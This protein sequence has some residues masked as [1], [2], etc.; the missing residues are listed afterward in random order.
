MFSSTYLRWGGKLCVQLEF[1]MDCAKNYEYRLQF[2]QVIDQS[3][4]LVNVVMISYTVSE[5]NG[6]IGHKI[7]TWFRGGGAF[8]HPEHPLN[9]ILPPAMFYDIIT[10]LS[11]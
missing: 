4:L 9:T 10:V 7:I 5:I 11:V 8:E 1:S 3:L 2:L 6:D